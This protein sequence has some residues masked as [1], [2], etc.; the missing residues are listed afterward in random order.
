MVEHPNNVRHFEAG[1]VVESERS[2]WLPVALDHSSGV[3]TQ[4]VRNFTKRA[5]PFVKPF[6]LRPFFALEGLDEF[7]LG[8]LDTQKLCVRLRS[9]KAVLRGGRNARHQLALAARKGPFPEQDGR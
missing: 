7:G 9:V 8:T 5:S 4:L 3:R 2:Q 1:L 6:D